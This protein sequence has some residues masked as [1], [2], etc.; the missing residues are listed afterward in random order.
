MLMEALYIPYIGNLITRVKIGIP[1][2]SQW[3]LNV[4]NEIDNKC[5]CV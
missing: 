1:T 3:Y 2:L 5:V 4:I